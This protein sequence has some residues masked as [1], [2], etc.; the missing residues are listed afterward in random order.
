MLTDTGVCIREMENVM[1]K[2]AI[3]EMIEAVEAAE[4]VETPEQPATPEPAETPETNESE[5]NEMNNEMYNNNKYRAEYFDTDLGIWITIDDLTNMTADNE[6]EAIEAAVDYL[7]YSDYEV[8]NGDDIDELKAKWYGVEWRAAQEIN[9]EY[10]A[11]YNW[12]Y[13]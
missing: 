1:K 4:K 6:L 3:D 2:T 11:D 8:G 7:A 12:K 13:E 5:V 10:N 9:P